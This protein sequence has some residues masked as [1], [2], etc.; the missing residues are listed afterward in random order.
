M[1]TKKRLRGPLVRLVELTRFLTVTKHQATRHVSERTT[2][3]AESVLKSA[4]SLFS[5]CKSVSFAD[6]RKKEFSLRGAGAERSS[7]RVRRLSIVPMGAD[8]FSWGELVEN[9]DGTE[10]AQLLGRPR[11]E[12]QRMR[13]SYRPAGRTPSRPSSRKGRRRDPAEKTSLSAASRRKD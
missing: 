6:I 5:L 13:A 11:S 3:E 7:G 1:P 9:S 12:H 2:A 10:F 8:D 4:K